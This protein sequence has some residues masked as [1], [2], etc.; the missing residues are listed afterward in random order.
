MISFNGGRPAKD[1]A[2]SER[3]LTRTV[4]VIV[5]EVGHNY[6]PM[7][8]NSDERQTTWMDEGLN[9]FLE[10]ET[11]RERYPTLDHTGN[12]PKGIVPFMKGD[13]SMMRPV[14]ATSDNQGRSFGP[15]GYSKPA[16][17]RNL[18]TSSAP[19]KMHPPLTLIGFG[20]DGFIPPTM[21]TSPLTT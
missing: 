4:S 7:I 17:A 18:P 6:F 19:W 3:T 2:I 1:G 11:M 16:A 12:T 13:K 9:S 10:K 15:N 14:M 5:H 21:L 20:G 8:I